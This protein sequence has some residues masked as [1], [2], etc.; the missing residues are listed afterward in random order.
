MG[1]APR[2]K[3]PRSVPP[4]EAHRDCAAGQVARRP[5]SAGVILEAPRG[6]DATAAMQRGFTCDPFAAIHAG[7]SDAQQQCAQ[8]GTSGRGGSGAARDQSGAGYGEVK[9]QSCDFPI[10]GGPPVDPLMPDSCSTDFASVAARRP[11]FQ[12]AFYFG[13]RRR[14]EADAEPFAF[15]EHGPLAAGVQRFSTSLPDAHLLQDSPTAAAASPLPEASTPNQDHQ[16]QRGHVNQEAAQ[17]MRPGSGGAVEA[18]EV[19]GSGGG[20]DVTPQARHAQLLWPASLQRLRRGARQSPQSPVMHAGGADPDMQPLGR[21][22]SGV[23]SPGGCDTPDPARQ[24]WQKQPSGKAEH[25]GEFVAAG[26]NV[27]RH[28]NH[29]AMR[30]VV[31]GT[32]YAEDGGRARGRARDGG[33]SCGGRGPASEEQRRP[34]RSPMM[35]VSRA[36]PGM[37]Q[38]PGSAWQ[39]AHCQFMLV[40][41]LRLNT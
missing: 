8:P 39:V 4:L 24:P 14:P 23:C 15:G 38:S 34:Q 33:H 5:S 3:H 2:D 21:H 7:A 6:H 9:A 26:E 35:E 28:A 40:Q 31:E 25:A 20:S 16:R 37:L 41:H 1:S 10:A 29:A 30:T 19:C 22:I 32:A 11:A 27:P 17:Q 12:A 13:A 18:M 36:G